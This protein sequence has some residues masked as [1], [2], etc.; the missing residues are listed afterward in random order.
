MFVDLIS[1]SE[2]EHLVC[3]LGKGLFTSLSGCVAGMLEAQHAHSLGYSDRQECWGERLA[4][5]RVL[6]ES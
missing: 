6:L 3:G 4:L 2:I 1:E 5:I